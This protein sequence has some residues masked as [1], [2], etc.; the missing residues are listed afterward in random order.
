[1]YMI[2][3]VQH[4]LLDQSGS[5]RKVLQTT[6]RSG[7]IFLSASVL[8][9]DKKVLELCFNQ[10]ILSAVL[11]YL[12]HV[13]IPLPCGCCTGS[14]KSIDILTLRSR[15]VEDHVLTGIVSTNGRWTNGAWWSDGKLIRNAISDSKVWKKKWPIETWKIVWKDKF[16]LS[17]A[18]PAATGVLVC[19]E[20]RTMVVKSYRIRQISVEQGQIVYTQELEVPDGE[21][22]VDDWTM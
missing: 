10:L 3:Y 9:S 17:V 8:K 16:L 1:M 21:D 15:S 18:T 12:C 2:H 7:N 19:W 22:V 6:R 11:L 13:D 14:N 4:L 20:A 5:F